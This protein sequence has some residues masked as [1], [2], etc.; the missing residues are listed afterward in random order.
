[1]NCVNVYSSKPRD[2]KHK[3][4]QHNS[5]M[6]TLNLFTSAQRYAHG[7]QQVGGGQGDMPPFLGVV[8]GVISYRFT[9]SPYTLIFAFSVDLSRYTDIGT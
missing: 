8:V 3:L 7:H 4:T 5:I 9:S 1:M 6:A 2:K